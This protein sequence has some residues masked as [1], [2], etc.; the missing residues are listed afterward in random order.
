MSTALNTSPNLSST[1]LCISH[2]IFDDSTDVTLWAKTRIDGELQTVHLVT[3]ISTLN[4]IL[5]YSGA[6]GEQILLAMADSLIHN[7]NPPYVVVLKQ[8]L[9][10]DAVITSCKLHLIKADDIAPE[11]LPAGTPPC[12][13]IDNV[14]PLTV[15]AQAQHLNQH[16]KDFGDADVV[17][18][19]TEHYKLN[20][21][22]LAKQYQYYQGLLQLDI[23]DDAAREK[24]GLTDDR[25]FKVA[26]LI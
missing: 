19:V 15:I 12:W 26:S 16:I 13:W 24:S 10:H 11:T 1:G 8:L 23:N 4:D 18:V 3:A 6:K 2:I 17:N 5:R 25:L 20:V 14:T 9:G 22:Q 21:T 7:E